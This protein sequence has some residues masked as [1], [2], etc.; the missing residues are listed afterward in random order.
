MLREWRDKYPVITDWPTSLDRICVF[1]LA[2]VPSVPSLPSFTPPKLG[3]SH[4][5][6]VE[7]SV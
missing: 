2:I 6:M 4:T 3:A 1:L 7:V 5:N